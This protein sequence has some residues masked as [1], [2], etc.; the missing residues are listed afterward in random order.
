M[1]DRLWAIGDLIQTKQ[2]WLQSLRARS[3]APHGGQGEGLG[4]LGFTGDCFVALLLAM[5][6][7]LFRLY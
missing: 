7:D 6:Y 5:T 3:P 2:I 4:H 1:G